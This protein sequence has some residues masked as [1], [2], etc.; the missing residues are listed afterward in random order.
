MVVFIHT[1]TNKPRLNFQHDTND[2]YHRQCNLNVF[3]SHANLLQSV[4]DAKQIE[5]GTRQRKAQRIRLAAALIKVDRLRATFNNWGEPPKIKRPSVLSSPSC[6]FWV[7]GFIPVARSLRRTGNPEAS[8]SRKRKVERVQRAWCCP[9]RTSWC[10]ST[11]QQ[12]RTK[13]DAAQHR[14]WVSRAPTGGKGRPQ[15]SVTSAQRSVG[16]SKMATVRTAQ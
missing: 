6:G 4:S 3:G 16:E 2:V 7:G 12:Q 1:Q 11:A 9:F 10:G 14:F 8:L 15:A 13:W 5:H